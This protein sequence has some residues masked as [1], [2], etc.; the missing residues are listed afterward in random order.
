MKTIIAI[1]TATDACSC[2]LWCDGETYQQFE[3]APRRHAELVLPMIDCLLNQQKLQCSDI[4][5]I[6]VGCGP[7]SFMGSRLA[8]SVAIG[9][10]LGL[11]VPVLSVS[12]LR[13]LAQCAY[14]ELGDV[15]IAAAWD[16]RMGEM[17]WG[18]YI[19]EQGIVRSVGEERLTKPASVKLPAIEATQR[20]VLVGNAW[21]TYH[22]QLPAEL[23]EKS[24]LIYPNAA[25][26]A[27]LAASALQRGER[28]VTAD[29][30]Q[31]NYLRLG[32]T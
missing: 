18:C 17:Y 19:A 9:L 11:D 5:A 30:V 7:G 21:Q 6:A 26:V 23:Q 1:E 12:S 22:N 4:D 14:Q 16:A 25:A 8:S 15:S 3:I 2:A 32:V 27:V 31:P 24:H 28:G 20:W 13:A 29:C 10:A